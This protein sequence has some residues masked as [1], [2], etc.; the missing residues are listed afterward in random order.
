MSRAKWLLAGATLA[1]VLITLW[2]VRESGER[3]GYVAHQ[4]KLFPQLP[5]QAGA[6]RRIEVHSA[7]R[8]V[9]LHGAGGDWMVAEKHDFPADPAKVRA[10]L[11]GLADLTLIEPRTADPAR[12]AALD[13]DLPDAPAARGVLVRVLGE[14]DAELAAVVLGKARVAAGQGP[15][16]MFVRRP[17]EDQ[18]WLA[19]G[20]V[21]VLRTPPL[22]LRAEAFDLPQARVREV[23]IQHP[24]AAPLALVRAA[25]D[26]PFRL[27]AALPKGR[28]PRAST[29]N[30]A[31]YG[32]QH[33]S[34]QD[35]YQPGEV[36]TD[37]DQATTVEF[38]TFDGLSVTA[39]VA[40]V[41][42]TPYVRLSAVVAGSVTDQQREA[43]TTEAARI[44]RDNEAWVYVVP[45]HT[46]A[47]FT[48]TLDDLLEP[49]PPPAG[50]PPTG[51]PPV[52]RMPGMMPGGAP[53]M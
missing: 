25:A 32:L 3:T 27:E 34:L 4:E 13:L 52:P 42:D 33:L 39:R 20:A 9:T 43:A 38:T 11:E 1:L 19:T 44:N 31:A 10:L 12:H 23:R 18:T 29:V 16:E 15:R 14:G 6:A 46:V 7:G 2:A 45:A 53:G 41:N 36:T 50:A 48:P 24:G 49:L 17:N 21:D 22:W 26:E 30:A 8:A 40:R 28:T 35:V 47:T 5:A 37:W 51:G